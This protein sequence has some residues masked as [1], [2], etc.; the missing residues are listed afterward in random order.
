[1]NNNSLYPDKWMFDCEV[2]RMDKNII[3][4]TIAWASWKLLSVDINT[5]M[6]SA[7]EL[8][9]AVVCRRITQK[10]SNSSIPSKK[11]HNLYT[12]RANNDDRK[13]YRTDDQ[14]AYENP[15]RILRIYNLVIANLRVQSLTD[16]KSH[17]CQSM[18]AIRQM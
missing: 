4:L 15:H 18:I 12:E 9:H 14:A 16:A 10:K 11:C 7:A 6:V 8:F 17:G 5:M 13:E 1:M 2:M 3:I